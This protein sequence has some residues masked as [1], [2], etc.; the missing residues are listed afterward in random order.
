MCN[1]LMFFINIYQDQGFVALFDK[2][3]YLNVGVQSGMDEDVTKVSKC[4]H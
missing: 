2:V 1:F 3:T 4:T